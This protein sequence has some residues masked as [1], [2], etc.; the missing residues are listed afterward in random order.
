MSGVREK[1]GPPRRTEGEQSERLEKNQENAVPQK[2]KE[3]IL[4]DGLS[5]QSRHP[6]GL[7]SHMAVTGPS[8][9]L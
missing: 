7:R 2:Q 1:E 9:K 3:G 8:S 5:D 6:R 4:Q